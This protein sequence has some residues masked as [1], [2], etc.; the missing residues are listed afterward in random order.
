[1]DFFILEL[2]HILIY[3]NYSCNYYVCKPKTDSSIS[4]I[5]IAD[6]LLSD[7]KKYYDE[8]YKFQNFG[9][10]IINN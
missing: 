7:L 10:N 5:P 2:F 1:M 6:E 4:D 8:V 9:K 3:I